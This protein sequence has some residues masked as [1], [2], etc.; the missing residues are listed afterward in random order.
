MISNSLMW[1]TIMLYLL[2]VSKILFP[3]IVLPYLTRVLSVEAFAV[4]VYVRTLMN[5]LQDIVNFGFLISGTKDIVA[6]RENKARLE[7]ELGTI[8]GATLLISFLTFFALVIMCVNI[9]L[10]FKNISYVMLSYVVVVLSC[11]FVEYFFRGLE[12]MEFIT[13]RYFFMKLFV[14]I[15]TF[16]LVKED[17]DVLW[18]PILDIIAAILAIG[19]VWRKIWGMN[20]KVKIG[21]VSY[22]L[23]KIKESAVYFAN[24]VSDMIFGALNTLIIGIYLTESQVSYWSICQQLI[25]GVQA[26]YYPVSN[27]I[28]PVMVKTRRIGLIKNILLIMTPLVLI[29][30]GVVYLCADEIIVFIAG[31]KYIEASGLLKLLVPVMFISF[32]SIICGWPILG[33]I[34]KQNDVT[35]TT[36]IAATSQVFG[37]LFLIQY[38]L[39]SLVNVSI[40][41]NL[42]EVILC[43]GRM[44][45]GLRYRNL[46]L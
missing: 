35:K 13:I 4:V 14:L 8:L 2:T 29:G 10:L 3:M 34:N 7:I 43:L 30:S 26:F 38:H 6:V 32:Y 5:C 39:F 46:F 1:N 37:L 21:K 25:G 44:F 31:E 19:F 22:V 45:F 15:L 18:I 24:S 33:A 17:N 20:V 42:S 28:F 12:I 41:R 40:L 9:P 36:V 16:F 11:F 27:S 23:I